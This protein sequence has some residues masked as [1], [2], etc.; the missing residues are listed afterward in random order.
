MIFMPWLRGER[1]R[2]NFQV[3]S[4]SWADYIYSELTIQCLLVIE[5]SE[6]CKNVRCKVCNALREKNCGWIRKESL[7]YHLKSEAHAYSVRAQQDRESIQT[8]REESMREESATEE[9]MD[10]AILSSANKPV[11][12][13]KTGF[14]RPSLEEEEMWKNYE[15]S[16]EIFDAGINHAMTAAE[17]R[18]RLEKEATNF[19]LWCDEDFVLENYSTNSERLLDELEQED[20]LT[21][22]LQ[23]I[24]P[25]IST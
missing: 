11:V 2:Q 1:N 25:F 5:L 13:A 22:L 8:A 18:R 10:F 24:P 20:L 19:G 6:D 21:E 4:F 3:V 9:R 12:A 17:Q 16:N 23:S 14:P 7:A 15:P